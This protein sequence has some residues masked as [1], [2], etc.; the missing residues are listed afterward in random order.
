MNQYE[1][2]CQCCSSKNW[3]PFTNEFSQCLGCLAYRNNMNLLERKP[4]P[5]DTCTDISVEEIKF[6][7]EKYTPLFVRLESLVPE[8]SI[9]DVACGCGGGVWLAKIRGWKAGGCEGNLSHKRQAFEVLG[10]NIDIGLDHF[11]ERL[12]CVF[13][14]HGIEHMDSPRIVFQ[15]ALDSLVLG[16]VIY[17]QHPV[18]PDE[19]DVDKRMINTGH[20]YEWTYGAFKSFLNTWVGIKFSG[21]WGRTHD[22]VHPSSQEWIVTKL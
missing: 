6:C 13:F 1:D 2:R 16:G 17:L 8:K 14:H 22:G 21:W 7:V 4:I 3:I 5:W 18:M 11:P 12:G 19:R 20:Q 15:Q 9:Y 10:V